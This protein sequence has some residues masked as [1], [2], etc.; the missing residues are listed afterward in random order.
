MVRM[1]Y[2]IYIVSM[3]HDWL[4]NLTRNV[5]TILS[6]LL[7][8]RPTVYIWY[9]V[10]RKLLHFFRQAAF[11]R[12]FA[13]YE[14]SVWTRHCL[15]TSIDRP[16]GV[17]RCTWRNNGS[18]GQDILFSH[19]R[20]IHGWTSETSNGRSVETCISSGD[21]CR[22]CAQLCLDVIINSKTCAI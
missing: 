3:P 14:V 21:T 2:Y 19:R 11:H 8:D 18:D 17:A 13:C 9:G 10:Y 15:S 20:A 22:C 5:T 12:L 6:T 4:G 7:T 16:G 1:K